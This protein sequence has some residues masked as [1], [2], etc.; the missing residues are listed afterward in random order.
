[1]AKKFCPLLKI[2]ANTAPIDAY[3]KEEK[4]A[5]WVEEVIKGDWTGCAI[6]SLALDKI[7]EVSN[8]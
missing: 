6:L 5:W 7:T 4:C 8:K 1:M 2:D 3:C